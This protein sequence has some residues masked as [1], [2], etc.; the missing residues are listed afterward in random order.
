METETAWPE[1]NN[2]WCTLHKFF[3]S[4]S[5]SANKKITADKYLK[6]NYFFYLMMFITESTSY[7]HPLTYLVYT[8]CT[9]TVDKIPLK[10]PFIKEA[11]RLL[12]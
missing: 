3:F 8:S 7:I 6:F 9:H 5:T 2:M 4:E 10:Y 1:R 11:F 12:L